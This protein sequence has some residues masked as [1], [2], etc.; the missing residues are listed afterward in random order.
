MSNG[1]GWVDQQWLSQL[2][3]YAIQRVG[4]LGLVGVAHVGL[5][6]GA[7][8]ATTVATRRL[9]AAATSVMVILPP[10]AFLLLAGQFEV[11]TQA[12]AYPLFVA[13]LY[14]LAMDSRS[15]SPRV[16]WVLPLLILWA[17]VHGSA[18]LGAGLVALR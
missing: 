8:A 11:R 3:M 13:V 7:V 4:G 1:H 17:N 16:Y 14:L 2:A 10:C 18:S 5:C 6:A 9:G 15:P 12:Y